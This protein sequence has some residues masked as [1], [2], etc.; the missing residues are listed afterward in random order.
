[1][2]LQLL[3]S[4]SAASENRSKLFRNAI[5]GTYFFDVL[6]FISSCCCIYLHSSR[7]TTLLHGQPK[8]KQLFFNFV[9]SEVSHGVRFILQNCTEN[10]NAVLQKAEQKVQRGRQ[11]PSVPQT[12]ASIPAGMRG[13]RESHPLSLTR[14][15][16]MHWE[17]IFLDVDVHMP[18]LLSVVHS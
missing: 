5:N 16:K 13:F 7:I 4:P 9:P 18:V 2:Q 17:D 6:A 11:L 10:W 12:Q 8:E 15:F 3:P 1:M 14:G